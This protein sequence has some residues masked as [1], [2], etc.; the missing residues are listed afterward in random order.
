MAVDFLLAEPDPGEL[1]QGQRAATDGCAGLTYVEFGSVAERSLQFRQQLLAP[2]MKLLCR[3]RKHLQRRDVCQG[4]LRVEIKPQGR[5][6]RG[7]GQLVDAQGACH[8]VFADFVDH[9]TAADDNACLGAAEQLV[10]TEG[11]QVNPGFQRF[12]HGRLFR[13]AVGCQVD[14]KAAAEILE[15]RYLMLLGKLCQGLTA[16]RF[17]ETEDAVV[18]G[19]HLENQRCLLADRVP[20]I[21]E[22]SLVGR[23]DFDQLDAAD[24]HDV[25]DAEGAADL[26]QL[27]A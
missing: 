5:F 24:S 23:T 25:G 1:G 27:T 14:E 2:L 9:R 22:M 7:Q 4:C 16:D 20:I 6:E 17:G 11:D 15:D 19:V 3:N 10:A 18:A 12:A 21:V 13:Q 8:R 26:D